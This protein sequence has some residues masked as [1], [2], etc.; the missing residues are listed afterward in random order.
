VSEINYDSLD[1]GIRRAVRVLAEDDA[2][3]ITPFESCDGS[4]GHASTQPIVRFHGS[5][6]AGWHA[7]GICLDRDLPVIS[8]ARTWQDEYGEMAGPFWVI[9][10]RPAIR[11]GLITPPYA[12]W[13][14]KATP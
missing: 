8:L 11:E 9:T 14:G 7:W 10:F 2:L 12:E 4:P 6:G 1:V 5:P 13:V 3:G